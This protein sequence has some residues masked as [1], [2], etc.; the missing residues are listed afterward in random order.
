MGKLQPRGDGSLAGSL[1]ADGFV[2]LVRCERGAGGGI[3]IRSLAAASSGGNC[4]GGGAMSV[5]GGGVGDCGGCM[6]GSGCAGCSGVD[7]VGVGGEVSC[8]DWRVAGGVCAGG[9]ARGVCCG[10]SGVGGCDCACGSGVRWPRRRRGD[11]LNWRRRGLMV[12]VLA[13]VGCRLAVGVVEGL[14]WLRGRPFGM[15]FSAL[16]FPVENMAAFPF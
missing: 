15:L 16:R 7:G 9:G 13:V 11:L 1:S 2:S 8:G 3:R 4:G 12:G 14:G 6:C 10:V 5:S